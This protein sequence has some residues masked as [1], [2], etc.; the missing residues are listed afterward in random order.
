MTPGLVCLTI[1]GICAIIS[2]V[3]LLIAAL[4]ISVWWALG[5]F[6]PFGPLLFRL[7]YPGVAQS[8]FYF[9]MG[10]LACVFLYFVLAPG[11]FVS[12]VHKRRATV[13]AARKGYASELVSKVFQRTPSE[14]KTD[15]RSLE[16]RVAANQREFQRLNGWNEALQT[17]K[18]DLLRSDVEANQAYNI[19]LQEYNAAL[20]AA[21]AEKQTLAKTSAGK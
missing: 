15:R 2:R 18:R 6:L 10:T 5:V 19:D 3:L 14:T 7:S 11:A 21:T 8:S 12:P 1:A 13:T 17:R 9:R 4:D 20:G 16:E